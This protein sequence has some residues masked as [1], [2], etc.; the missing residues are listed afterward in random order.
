[1]SPG[2]GQFFFSILDWDPTP[3]SSNFVASMESKMEEPIDPPADHSDDED[4][5]SELQGDSGVQLG[6]IEQE[7]N[8][9]FSDPDWR[10]W[11]GGK[12]GGT[13]VNS[14]CV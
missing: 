12:V 13:P 11:D 7:T 9:L 8:P 4:N 3:L 1:M 5:E 2:S 10:N 6:Y 14:L